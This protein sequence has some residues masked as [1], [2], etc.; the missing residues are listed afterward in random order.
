VNYALTVSRNGTGAGTVTSSPAG[1]DCGGD[2]S[3]SFGSGT[4]VTLIATAAG[5]SAFAGWSGACTGNGSCLVTMS[6]ARSVTATFDLLPSYLLTV[7]KNGAGSGT[8]SSS[9][10]GIDCGGDCS[11]SYTSGTP[12]VLTAV[13]AALSAFT[14]WTGACTGTGSCQV[15]MDAARNVGA[16]FADVSACTTTVSNQTVATA[17]TVEDCHGILAGPSL[18]VSSPGHL[19]LRAAAQVVLRNGTSIDGGARLT[20][21]LDPSLAGT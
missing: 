18:A 9:P 19:T 2:C 11:E 10:A 8:V 5:G 16:G 13:A 7:S 15:T 14:G 3:E 4:Q 12:V 21:A 1:I 6:A 17:V 20:V